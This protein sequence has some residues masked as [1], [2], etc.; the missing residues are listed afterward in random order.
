MDI[1]KS[2]CDDTPAGIDL[3]CRTALQ[4]R[5]QRRNA[6]T[7]DADIGHHAG[8]A[9]AVDD[10]AVF[11][12]QIIGHPWAPSAAPRCCAPVL[13]TASCPASMAI[14][15]CSTCGTQYPVWRGGTHY[16]CTRSGGNNWIQTAAERYAPV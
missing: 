1:D 14:A 13:R 6:P 10:C 12:Q 15:V 16:F 8:G 5:C 7:A 11:D 3:A 4:L 9:G 2:R